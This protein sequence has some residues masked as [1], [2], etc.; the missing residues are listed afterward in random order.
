MPYLYPK[1]VG[2]KSIRDAERP[3][4]LGLVWPERE[5]FIPDNGSCTLRR[6]SQ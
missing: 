3:V 4:W 5:F 6:L 2:A 1:S